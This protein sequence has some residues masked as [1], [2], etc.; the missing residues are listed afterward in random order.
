MVNLHYAQCKVTQ[1]VILHVSGEY[2]PESSSVL[3][4]LLPWHMKNIRVLHCAFPI[5]TFVVYNYK[6]TFR[7]LVYYIFRF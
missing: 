2:F 1:V 3:Q 6:K 7:F 5:V 4:E